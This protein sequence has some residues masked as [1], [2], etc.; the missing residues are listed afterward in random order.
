[1]TDS[2]GLGSLRR[3]LEA[4]DWAVEHWSCPRSSSSDQFHKWRWWSTEPGVFGVVCHNCGLKATNEQLEALVGYFVNTLVLRTDASGDPPFHEL[5]ARAEAT[6]LGAWDHQEVLLLA[7][8]H[9]GSRPEG[10][11]NPAPLPEHAAGP[12]KGRRGGPGA[13]PPAGPTRL[14]RAELLRAIPPKGV[15]L[16]AAGCFV[17]LLAA[18]SAALW[19][20]WALVYGGGRP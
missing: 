17:A 15:R 7:L 20:L 12:P 9:S 8:L 13:E 14:G 10:G 2:E 4:T 11:R 16:R 5:V 1:M 3:I 19:T 6:F 18:G